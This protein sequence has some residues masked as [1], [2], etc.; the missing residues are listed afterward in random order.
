METTMSQLSIG[1]GGSV[2]EGTV[3]SETNTTTPDGRVCTPVVTATPPDGAAPE[4]RPVEPTNYISEYV[5]LRVVP[6]RALEPYDPYG[7]DSL[8]YSFPLYDIFIPDWYVDNMTG[9]YWIGVAEFSNTT[10]DEEFFD[11][12]LSVNLT[13]SNMTR[14]Y[15]TNYTVRV[16]TSSCLFYNTLSDSWD[17][18]GCT[19]IDANHKATMCTCNHLTSF[20]SGFFVMP[21]AIDFDYV[22]AN[23]G[24]SGKK[25]S[26]T[27]LYEILIITGSKTNSECDSKVQFILSGERD[28][29]DVRTLADPQRPI[30]RR[31]A[32]DSFVMATPRPLGQL[33]YLRIWHD[34]SGKG[35]AASW[36]LNFMV[37]RDVQTGE[38]WQFIANKWFAVEE[39]DGQIDRLLAVAGREQM[40]QFQHLFNTSSRKN[41]SD[42][43]LWF[44]VF[45][46]PPRSRFTRVQRV[47]ACMALLYLS[48]LVN[49]MWY[50]LVPQQ[51]RTG[52]ISFGPFSLSPEQ[53]GVGV[54]ANLIVFPPSFLIVLLFRKW[55]VFIAWFL[56]F[57]SMGA[58]IFF[59]WAYGITFGNEKT[60][61][62]LTSLMISFISSVLL[63]QPIKVLLTAMFVSAVC[64]KLDDGHDDIDDDEK[65]PELQAD[66]EWMHVPRKK[67]TD[68]KVK[69]QPVD[70]AKI[71]AAKRER[72]KEIKMWDILQEMAA[73]AFFLWVLLT[74][75][76]GSRDPNCYLIR[77]SLE[78]HFLQ[79]NDYMLSFGALKIDTDY[80]GQKPRG[81]EKNLISDRVHLL[82]GN[83]VMRQVRIREENTCRVPKVMRNLTRECHKFSNLLYE[84]SGDFGLGWNASLAHR[85]PFNLKE[86]R[87][88]SASSLD[89]YPFW[90]DLGWYGGGG[91]VVELKGSRARLISEMWRLQ[92]QQWI[93]E[94]TRAV[95]IEFSLFNAQVN[96]FVGCTIVAEFGPDGGIIPF[97]K[98]QPVRLQTYNSGFGLFVLICD[99]FGYIIGFLVFFGTLKFIKLLRFNKRMGFLT[100]TL[101][102]C[103]GDLVGF[104]VVFVVIFVAFSST[105]F[106]LLGS[107]MADFT[108][109]IASVEASFAMMLGKFDFM[110][111]SAANRVLGPLMLFT[112]TISMTCV[113]INIFL[114]VIIKSFQEVKLD[115]MKQGNEYEVI[116]FLVNRM[117]L[118]TGIGKPKLNS[119][120]P[121]APTSTDESK[122]DP[123]NQFPEK[124]DQLLNHVN[125]FY[126]DGK[127][128]LNNKS[129]LKKTIKMEKQGANE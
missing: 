82:L 44:S 125:D 9:E 64:K 43:H 79:P 59:L 95:F 11:D 56:T 50:G 113:F 21:N 122:K 47:S 60:T 103:A 61:K 118:M 83:G 20:G 86:Y 48:M 106:L 28:E 45:M 92:E 38:K 101:K 14:V 34:N 126:F 73:Y 70:P 65:D 39:G 25:T 57:A 3:G 22:F 37:V 105:F 108:N 36:Y 88:R 85:R 99:T 35:G 46:R 55:C 107:M 23:A 124:V 6:N 62:W 90:G 71:E 16:Y 17:S 29:T 8:L 27:Y 121:L 109:I 104:I 40:L 123:S 100:S 18:D 7:N 115:L 87:H 120:G 30:L 117:K 89:S 129:W 33:S 119:V 80:S 41:L 68:R 74:I 81:K 114:T 77:E 102:Q 52:S 96:L 67:N 13:I 127:M 2:T 98:F 72:Q 84:E 116:E 58:S 54:M 51:P 32:T 1:D 69:Y 75:S 66:E 111:I 110:G 78:N 63:T 53:I 128:D 31:S 5:R 94:K 97:F 4:P 112:F 91:Y 10:D 42:G 76:Y 24:V 49:A 12:P 93:D 26:E 19:V 15:S